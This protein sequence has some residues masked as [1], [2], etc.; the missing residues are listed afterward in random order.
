V[1]ANN[2]AVFDVP[3]PTVTETTLFAYGRLAIGYDAKEGAVAVIVLDRTLPL[4][5]D[6]LF[7]VDQG[8]IRRGPYQVFKFDG[9]AIYGRVAGPGFESQNNTAIPN[10]QGLNVVRNAHVVWTVTPYVEGSTPSAADPYRWRGWY[11]MPRPGD[12]VSAVYFDIVLPGGVAWITDK[13]DYLS[14]GVTLAID[15]QEIDDTSSPIG[16]ATRYT[17]TIQGATSTPQRITFDFPLPK[18][19]RYRVRIARQNN[20]D[21]RAS[22][23][24]SLT[25]LGAIRGRIYH[26][27][28][29]SAYENATL[30]AMRFVA[31]AGLAAA[32][33]R[34]IRV[35]C[36]R[37]LPDLTGAGL[38][39]TSN[40]AYALRDL[41]TN[42]NYGA[43][44]PAAELDT[45]TL[46]RLAPQWGTTAGFNGI[47]DQP[48]TVI[49]AAQAV[50][51]PVAAMPLPIGSTL[52]VAQDCPRPYA[53]VFGPDT[54]VTDTLSLGY[55]FDGLDEPDCLEVVYNDPATFAEMRVFYPVQGI[56]PESVELFGC[57][58]AAQALDWGR[59]RWQEKQANRKT[60]QFD[61]EGEGYLLEPLTHFG[62]VVPSI[63]RG[64]AGMVTG[65]RW[66]DVYLDTPFPTGAAVIHFKQWDGTIGPPVNVFRY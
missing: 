21:Q 11:S 45:T 59:L 10:T 41:Y 39:A 61:L 62:L 43:G 3:L 54:I 22:K 60:C 1:G 63:T 8:G 47:F 12:K 51:A 7:D 48:I 46:A 14:L 2:A 53:F 35:D 19:A 29:T 36:T 27:P 4:K 24:I 49:E 32:A 9:T 58:S 40:P 65:Y 34:R 26:A 25:Q 16:T 20:R 30:I 44:R 57:T 6:E 64:D 17:R 42:T 15:I 52:S 31:N 23:E 13:G 18:P 33:S 55:N 28:G 38:T 50:L 66:P 37:K 5:I 56:K